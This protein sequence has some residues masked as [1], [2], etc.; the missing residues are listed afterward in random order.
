[1]QTPPTA[2]KKK[3]TTRPNKYL[4]YYIKKKFIFNNNMGVNQEIPCLYHH[5][6]AQ[7][8]TISQSSYYEISHTRFEMIYSMKQCLYNNLFLV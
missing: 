1:M 2:K 4:Y 8:V 7:Q 5:D 3:K 6:R